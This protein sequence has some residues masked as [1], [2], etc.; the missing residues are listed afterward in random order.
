MANATSI[1]I[2]DL[3]ANAANVPPT[4][5]ILDTGTAAVV[6]ET[7]DLAGTA[8]RCFLDV[9]NTSAQ[10]L[11]V[12]IS[13]GDRPPSFRG[14]IAVPVFAAIAASTGRQII[15]IS[16]MARFLEGGGKLKFTFTPT[17]GTI[18]ATFTFYRLPRS[19]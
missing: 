19:G 16:D 10:T 11:T 1:A 3:V 12:S 9:Y 14:G 17:S 13:A 8:H 4:A 6:L 7:P 18:A 15:V 2:T 5:Q